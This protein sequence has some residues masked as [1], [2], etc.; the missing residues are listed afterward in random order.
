M[1]KL[2]VILGPTASGKTSLAVKIASQNNGEIISADSRQIYKG[3]DIGTGKDLQEYSIENKKIPYHL[4][5]I[6]NPNQDY[7]VFQFKNDFHKI[8]NEINNNKKIPILCGG[9]ALYIDSILFNYDMSGVKPNKILREKLEN[10]SMEE[11]LVKLEKIDKKAYE[12]SFHNTK[13]RIIRTIEILSSSKANKSTSK[14]LK[15]PLVIGI[16]V[17]R[18]EILLKIKDRLIYRLNNGMI[19]EVEKLISS[20]VTENR[21][22]YF[23]LEYKY[24]GMYLYEKISYDEMVE[25]LN[26]GINRF[27]KRQM[28]FFRRMEKWGIKINWIENDIIESSLRLTEKYLNDK[29]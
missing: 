2:I 20:G 29:C 23:G 3:M 11:L 8:Y 12:E 26:I 5:D 24:I 19:E 22:N 6:L 9:T 16:K 18:K 27:S 1:E 28:T 10:F 15:N 14:N 25:K 17:E 13:R 7:S 4:I 21:L